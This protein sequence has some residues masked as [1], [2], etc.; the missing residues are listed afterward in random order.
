MN[1]QFSNQANQFNPSQGGRIRIQFQ[2]CNKP[3][4]SALDCF[5]SLNFAYQGKHPQAQVSAMAT[6]LNNSQN[7]SNLWITDSGA[8]THIMP[9]LANLSL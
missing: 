1:T 2:I 8:S 7:S 9:D 6:S 5:H 4:H 3:G